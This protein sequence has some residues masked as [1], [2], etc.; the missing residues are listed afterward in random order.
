MMLDGKVTRVDIPEDRT[1]IGIF[2]LPY[3]TMLILIPLIPYCSACEMIIYI[4]FY[5][6]YII[7]ILQDHTTVEMDSNE[8]IINRF[9]SGPVRINKKDISQTET[10]ENIFHRFRF[11]GYIFMFTFLLY[12]ID[13]VYHGIYGALIRNYPTEDLFFRFLSRTLIIIFLSVLFYLMERR[14]RVT[15]VLEIT[16]QHKKYKFYTHKPIEF[17]DLILNEQTQ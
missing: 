6:S 11:P 3:I 12:N 10:K 15:D 7:L 14:L 5:L 16:T 9:L 8:I 13:N 4:I 2:L 1:I 17:R